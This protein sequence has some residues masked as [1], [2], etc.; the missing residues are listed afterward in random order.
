MRP[1]VHPRLQPERAPRA[2]R[3]TGEVP[4][5]RTQSPILDVRKS[6]TE[7]TTDMD[8]QIELY[9]HNQIA[10]DKLRD[11]L[12]QSDRACVIQPTG[13][14]KFVIIAKLVQDNPDKRFLLL[15]T[16]DYMYI[17]QMDNLEKIA[18]GFHPENLQFKTYSAAM[19]S[20]RS[21]MVSARSEH[22]TLQYDYIILDEFHHCG[23]PEWSKGVQWFIDGNP[24]AKL[25]GFSA[26]PIRFSD[27]GRDMADEI[28]AGN[29]ASSM[30]LEE[31]WLRSILPIPKYV[32][33]LYDAPKEL[34]ELKVSIEK[35]KDKKKFSK[36][37]KKYEELRRSL[38]DAEGVDTAI[39][40]HLKK[41]DAK[42]IVFCPNNEKLQ[43]FMALSHEW[44]HGVNDVIHTYKT[45]S[46]DPN[47]SDDFQMFKDDDSDALK[48]LYCINQLNEAVHISG[49]DAIVM[50]RP[51]KSPVIFH[52]QLGRALSSGSN[53]TPLVFDLCNNFGS[54]GGITGMTER[55]ERAYGEMTE[56][57]EKPIHDPKDFNVIDEI[58]D[59]RELAAELRDALNPKMSID[60]KIAFLEE[61][62]EMN[63]GKL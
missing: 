60:D 29:I 8:S 30:E 43:E 63:G 12:S 51:T 28:F 35:V 52:Q 62:A 58:K 17:D 61:I 37:T 33:A 41:R 2:R 19:V 10:Y 39:A 55:L 3:V 48:V 23:A 44:F 36:F 15:G 24:D 50:V 57:G 1:H 16:N 32:I 40:K 49:I 42:I 18:P 25:L 59:P 34:S 11:M 4:A 38:Q 7:R 13:T 46:A 6:R 45:T 56:C 22:V 5:L 54:L 20:A 9:P 21:E 47:G 31:A 26:T 14:G 27:D 53:D